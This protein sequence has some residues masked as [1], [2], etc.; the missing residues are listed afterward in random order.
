VSTISRR[1]ADWIGA[2][3][4]GTLILGFVAVI[5]AGTSISHGRLRSFRELELVP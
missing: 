4:G 5:L 1:V 2:V 3:R